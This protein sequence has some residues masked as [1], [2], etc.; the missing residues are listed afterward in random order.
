MTRTR[1]VGAMGMVA[2]CFTAATTSKVTRLETSGRLA[3]LCS[4]GSASGAVTGEQRV[5]LTL[6]LSGCKLH[7]FPC[8]NT[9]T[10]GTIVTSALTGVL[11]YL[12]QATKQVGLDLKPAGATVVEF[13]CG[14]V[15]VLVQGSVVGRISPVNTTVR[16]PATFKL[17]FAQTAGKE[18]F[19]E[20]EGGPPDVLS[21]SFGGG[22][23]QVSG[24]ASA[25]A[26]TFAEPVRITA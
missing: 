20:L 12:V 3:I 17:V 22:P 9:S 18:K 5:T 19:G 16:P 11:G 21:S 15:T 25:S 13:L 24:L 26:L 4:G 10:A 6:T 14:N 1:R 7:G 8:S 23:F 2:A